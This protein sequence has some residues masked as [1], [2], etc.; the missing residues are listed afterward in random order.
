MSKSLLS[1]SE[2]FELPSDC[3]PRSRY[4]VAVAPHRDDR[5][6]VQVVRRR[7]ILRTRLYACGAFCGYRVRS[8]RLTGEVRRLMAAGV[9]LRAIRGA[10]TKAGRYDRHVMRIEARRRDGRRLAIG[11]GRA[12]TIPIGPTWISDGKGWRSREHRIASALA[13]GINVLLDREASRLVTT[14]PLTL[15]LST[16]QAKAA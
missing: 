13:D 10:M 8:Y 5:P 15:R 9:A 4:N 3:D 6:D 2:F 16:H 1:V 11:E 12:I 7:L 14:L